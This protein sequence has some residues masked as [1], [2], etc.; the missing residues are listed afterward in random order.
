LVK[1]V[2]CKNDILNEVTDHLTTYRKKT[3]QWN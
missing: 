1:L 3:K 2:P